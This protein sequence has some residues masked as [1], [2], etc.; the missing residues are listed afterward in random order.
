VVNVKAGT[1]AIRDGST[2]TVDGSTGE[3]FLEGHPA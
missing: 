3:V 2:V 1:T